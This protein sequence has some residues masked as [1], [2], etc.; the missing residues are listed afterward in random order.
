MGQG[1]R[2]RK[3]IGRGYRAIVERRKDASDIRSDG[4]TLELCGMTDV[5]GMKG[6]ETPKRDARRNV[7]KSLVEIYA[8]GILSSS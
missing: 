2:N 4:N 1:R 7:V 3:R 8:G 6:G 5:R